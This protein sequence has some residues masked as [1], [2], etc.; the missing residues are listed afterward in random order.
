MLPGG[1]DR[2]GQNEEEKWK[3]ARIQGGR[4]QKSCDWRKNDKYLDLGNNKGRNHE[5]GETSGDK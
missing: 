2:E 1:F 4:S 3:G 5:R